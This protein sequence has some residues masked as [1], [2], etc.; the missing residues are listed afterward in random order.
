M[1]D[2]ANESGESIK[3][4]GKLKTLAKALGVSIKIKGPVSII[5]SLL[6][7]PAAL[8]PVW[9]AGLLRNLTDELQ[10]LTGGG[11]EAGAALAVFGGL[12]GLYIARMIINFLE[13]FVGGMDGIKIRTYIMRTIMRRKCDVRY[14]YIENYDD[15]QKRVTFAEEHTGNTM[16]ESMGSIIRLMQLVVAFAAASFALWA[17]SPVIVIVLYVTSL[18]AAVLAYFQQDETFHNR[19]KWMEEGHLAITY[20]NMIA[21][22]GYLLNGQQEIRHGGLFEYLKKRWREITDDYLEKKRR[23]TAK[24][25]KYNI[26]ADFLRS[27]VY[28][29][30][31]LIAAWEIYRDPYIGLGVFALVY[32]LSGQ[33]QTVTANTFVGVMTLAQDIPYMQEF[34]Y[35]DELEREPRGEITKIT[36]GDIVFENVD[37]AYPKSLEGN[38]TTSPAPDVLKGINLRIKDGEKIAIVGENGS[39]KST[40]INLLCGMHEPKNGTCRIGGVDVSRS[41]GATRDAVSVVFQ[42]FAHYEAALRENITV[43]DKN[44]VADDAEIM[45]LLEKINVADVVQ[46][47]PNGLNEQVGTFADKSNNLSGGQWQKISIARAA[48]R[49]NAPIM[50]L[51]EPTS[52][53][54]PIAEAL[55]YKNF[56]SLTGGK[57]TILISHRLGITAIVDRI[58]VFKDGRIVEDGTHKELMSKNGVYTEMYHAQAKWYA[59]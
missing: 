41:P 50:V 25:V 39:G 26:A 29:G 56:A 1:N 44:R 2:N 14:K 40:L 52:A 30:I 55:L 43:S 10:A 31:L 42:D 28:V 12:V 37:F 8:I 47:Q 54:D 23:L 22:A 36:S 6:G 33:L 20:F 13:Q 49:K 24:H 58:L 15:F 7:F 17:V 57:T 4:T 11:G 46:E 35:L 27:G 3:K 51:D 21:G 19:A 5:V 45:D 32:A 59:Q 18:P 48:Y 16:A 38:S 34:F 53:L 9:L